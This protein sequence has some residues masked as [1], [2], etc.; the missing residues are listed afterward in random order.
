MAG[1]TRTKRQWRRLVTAVVAVALVGAGLSAPALAESSAQ[2]FDE[3]YSISNLQVSPVKQNQKSGRHVRLT[4]DEPECGGVW[5]D[6]RVI[7]TDDYRPQRS[8]EFVTGTEGAAARK[9]KA[10]RLYTFRVQVG[11][12]GEFD[13]EP[14]EVSVRI[15]GNS[16]DAWVVSLGDSFISGEGGRWAGNAD[17]LPNA[18][19]ETDT[20]ER[21]YFDDEDGETIAGCHRSNAALI[22]IGTVRSMN[23]ACSGAITST[24]IL[25]DTYPWL[26]D[27]W[28]PGIDF[29]DW[30]DSDYLPIG[31]DSPAV[32]QAQLLKDFARGKNVKMVMLSIGGNNFGFGSIVSACV[33]AY[34]SDPDDETGCR[35]QSDLLSKLNETGV[36]RT[37]AQIVVAI[38][39]IVRAMQESGHPLGTWTLGYQMYP[40]PL[41]DSANMRYPEEQEN[42]FGS[43]E[44]PRQ[45]MGG[46][47]LW[48]ADIDWA[49]STAVPTINNTLLAAGRE[50]VA[51]Y[52]GLK[53][54]YLDTTNAFRGH[55]LCSKGVYR[56]NS[57][58]DED[59]KGVKNW[60]NKDAADKSE[61]VKE[62]DLINLSGATVEESFHPNY[63]GQMALRNCWRQLYEA[64]N[65]LL[66]GTCVP[67]KGV[68]QDYGE[69]EMKFEPSPELTLG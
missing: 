7:M 42:V 50:A 58:N 25:S 19:A 1:S 45:D 16:T 20:G 54:V 18:R 6:Y 37:K 67:T 31:Y 21:S 39:N 36:S 8:I 10:G 2:D 61:W 26:D 9:L 13:Q 68:R 63:W 28:K 66:G 60:R 62:I 40:R 35:T 56:V 69:P 44:L 4:W 11:S 29:E 47:G 30:S 46:C 15:P 43:I 59:R 23:L 55:E 17:V 32:G 38:G 49:L 53:I 64:K 52:P 41:P 5:D 48:D 57:S 3:C 34:I 14:L 33:T 22:H 24:Q 65:G 27:M 51:Q 12:E